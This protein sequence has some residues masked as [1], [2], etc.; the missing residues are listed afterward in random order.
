MT[1]EAGKASYLLVY[2]ARGTASQ[3]FANLTDGL[4]GDFCHVRRHGY[5]NNAREGGVVGV[6]DGEGKTAHAR[7]ERRRLQQL[8]QIAV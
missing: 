3:T 8:I 1:K 5:V 4:S 6:S 7:I 2:H